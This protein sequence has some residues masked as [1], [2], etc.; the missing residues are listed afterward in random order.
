M[1]ECNTK[2]TLISLLLVSM[3]YLNKSSVQSETEAG[4]YDQSSA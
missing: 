3:R 2:N 4:D 1:C